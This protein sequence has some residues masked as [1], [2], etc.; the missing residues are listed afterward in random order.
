M[1]GENLSKPDTH[2]ENDVQ[3]RLHL[4]AVSPVELEN[5]NNI[6]PYPA[7]VFFGISQFSSQFSHVQ[8]HPVGD[9]K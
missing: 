5:L 1:C 3:T 8:F 7:R 6:V 4:Q 9:N 2:L